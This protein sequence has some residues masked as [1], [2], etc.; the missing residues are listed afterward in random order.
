MPDTS[1]CIEET[2]TVPHRLRVYFTRA[3]FSCENNLLAGLIAKPEG[4]NAAKVLMVCDANAVD[5]QSQFQAEVAR[6]LNTQ[7]GDV[8]FTYLALPGGEVV[9]NET[10]YLTQLY[11]AIESNQLCRHS[12]IIA[13]GG[14]AL[15][16]LVGYA[17]ATAHRG[18]RLIRMPTTTLSQGDGGVGVK[19]SV[20]AYGKKNF[21]GSFAVPHAV[22]N[23]YA[24]LDALPERQM[25]D[26]YIEALKVGL[27]RDRDFVEWIEAHA[28]ALV[29][30]DPSAVERLIERSAQHHVNHIVQGGDPFEV[31][32]SRPLDFGHWVAHKLEQMSAFHISHG[33][34][35]ACGIA[36]DTLYSAKSGT[37]PLA[38]AERILKVIQQLG[39]SI[40]YPELA[41][42][43][44]QGR[45]IVMQGLYEFREHLGGQLTIC[46]LK[47][48]GL[49]YDAHEINAEW[50]QEC[51]E[52]LHRYSATSKQTVSR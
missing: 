34:A 28:D 51:I 14:G 35:V 3:V 7:V 37:L 17:A 13:V 38:D 39:F 25:R 11:D 48:I 45:L 36:L 32:S 9:K 24:F 23:D 49:G 6:Y 26:G 52:S 20:N 18:I 16:D 40:Y 43:D 46:L 47:A 41:A 30:R 15:L 21:I 31:G 19:N 33:E 44:S 8:A 42:T 2:F 10:H 12:Y 27:I 4:A 5:C 22:I 29:L 1:T 50:I